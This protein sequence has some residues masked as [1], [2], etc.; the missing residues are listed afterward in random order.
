M[1]LVWWIAGVGLLL[2]VAI[3]TLASAL[4]ANQLIAAMLTFVFVMLHY[5]LG[6]MERFGLVSGSRWSEALSYFSMSEHMHSLSEGL[7]DSRPIVYY[8]SFSVLLLSLTH[9][10]LE[11]RKWRA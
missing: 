8:L 5:F 9:H 10:I 2:N 11:S 1:T 4:T 6:F 7:I 3:G